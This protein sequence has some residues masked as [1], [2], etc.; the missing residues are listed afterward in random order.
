MDDECLTDEQQ[1]A[2]HAVIGGKGN[3]HSVWSPPG[4]GK[5]LILAVILAAWVKMNSRCREAIRPIAVICTGRNKLRLGL[6]QTLRS[7]LAPI[8]AADTVLVLENFND[9][10]S[11]A[12]A[13]VFLHAAKRRKIQRSFSDVFMKLKVFDDLIDAQPLQFS[14]RWHADRV[15][16]LFTNY[17]WQLG[18]RQQVA[19]DEVNA[20]VCT[21]DLLRKEL[22]QKPT[23]PWMKNR[24][25][26]LLLHDEVEGQKIT[27]LSALTLHFDCCI[28]CGDAKNQT[29]P[30]T[31]SEPALVPVIDPQLVA[32]HP[33]SPVLSSAPLHYVEAP[34]TRHLFRCANN[35]YLNG[36][37]R[38]A[39][40]V[41]HLLVKIGL[42]K[43]GESEAWKSVAD[44]ET[45]VHLVTIELN[46]QDE[47]CLICSPLFSALVTLAVAW[48]TTGDGT[49]TVGIILFYKK[50]V[51][52]MHQL[53]QDL[54][55]AG[56]NVQCFSFL[57]AFLHSALLHF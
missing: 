43:K 24:R 21:A 39:D 4:C 16:E 26:Q 10:Q 51:E 29:I 6:L 13:D 31:R 52:L 48:L 1:V 12:D 46:W 8:N 44:H 20:V 42:V 3:L 56:Y 47:R 23:P 27:D 9:T 55:E 57:S 22:Q 53:V 40:S 11:E 45:C 17:L 18:A 14:L 30:Y 28:T 2:L 36:V 33:E 50:T 7:R 35:I 54:S 25:L 41:I 19:F 5:S 32:M 34:A 38:F 15:K 37:H 49:C